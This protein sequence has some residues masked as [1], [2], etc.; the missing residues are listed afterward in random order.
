MTART[1]YDPGAKVT[2]AN[3][4]TV[5]RLVLAVPFFFMI[6]E[7][8]ATW[9]AFWWGFALAAS[10]GL[11]GYLARRLGVT[12]SGAFLDP[13]ADKVLALGSL[14]VLAGQGRFPWLPVGLIA[15]REVGISAFRSYA[16]RRG[17][18]VPARRVAKLK[19]WVQGLAVGLALLPV[20]DGRADWV[21][22]VALWVAVALTLTT[23]L[24]Y[25]R[26]GRRILGR[27]VSR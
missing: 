2:P 12:R 22:D 5:V 10:D 14:S 21:A 6:A 11:D 9:T 15:A 26:D 25:L 17:I 13:L 20:L 1:G 27:A 3:L 23:G 4:V 8:G 18:S 16:G 7:W 19:T 24:D